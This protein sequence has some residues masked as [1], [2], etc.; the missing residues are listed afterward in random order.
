MFTLLLQ[1]IEP[2]TCQVLSTYLL[3][4]LTIERV[5]PYRLSCREALWCEHYNTWVWML[6]AHTNAHLPRV[7]LIVKIH[8]QFLSS[9]QYIN[10]GIYQAERKHEVQI[11]S[12]WRDIFLGLSRREEPGVWKLRKRRTF[13]PASLALLGFS[14]MFLGDECATRVWVFNMYIESWCI[15]HVH[16]CRLRSLRSFRSLMMLISLMSMMPSRSLISSLASWNS[17]KGNQVCEEYPTK[18]EHPSDRSHP[19]TKLRGTLT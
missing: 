8:L 10:R 13:N 4:E 17:H 11:A 15:Q 5:K 12:I 2:G 3:D 14:Q 9:F 7:E 19:E 6:H 1:W 18:D 16:R